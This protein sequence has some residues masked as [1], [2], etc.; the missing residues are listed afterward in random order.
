MLELTE[1][2][3][4]AVGSIVRDAAPD[5]LLASGLRLVGRQNGEM[6]ELHVSLALAP[7]AGDHV[8]EKGGAR[9]FLDPAAAT[10]LSE[11]RLDASTTSGEIRF[12]LSEQ[13]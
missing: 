4:N 13:D 5:S 9:L 1:D 3:V 11:K 10:Y 12:Q 7:V 8:V 2:A 6:M